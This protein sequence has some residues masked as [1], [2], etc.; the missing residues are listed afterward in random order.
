MPNWVETR[1]YVEGPPADIQDWAKRSLSG[2]EIKEGDPAAA[3]ARAVSY[4]PAGR[5]GEGEFTFGALTGVPDDFAHNWYERGIELWGTKWDVARPI[6]CG[7]P[8]HETMREPDFGSGGSIEIC[9]ETAWSPAIPYL[10]HMSR[11][12]PDLAISAIF[13]DEAENFSGITLIQDGYERTTEFEVAD[14]V[15]DHPREEDF[16]SEEEWEDAFLGR[17]T[18]IFDRLLEELDA[19]RE[20]VL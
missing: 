3:K 9:W 5:D 2:Y 15:G 8:A 16:D 20:V 11:D 6:V 4:L 18:A 1:V 10:L 13:L 14:L 12:Y 19:A 7:S 17:E